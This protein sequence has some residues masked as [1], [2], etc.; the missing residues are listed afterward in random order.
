MVAN[1]VAVVKK[2]AA[3]SWSNIYFDAAIIRG[4][5]NIS[6][7]MVEKLVAVVKKLVAPAK[8]LIAA[9]EKLVAV[10]KIF[11]AAWLEYS[12]RHGLKFSRGCQK[13]CRGGPKISRGMVGKLALIWVKK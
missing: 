2:F 11:A 4:G 3:A 10:V 1:L 13:I 9:E 5:R 7:G 12:L 8:K 6:C